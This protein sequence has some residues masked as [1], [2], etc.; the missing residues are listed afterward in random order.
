MHVISTPQWKSIK[1]VVLIFAT[2]LLLSNIV[3]IYVGINSVETVA[4]EHGLSLSNRHIEVEID[5]ILQRLKLIEIKLEL[6]KNIE[7]KL[8]KK[9]PVRQNAFEEID[10][11]NALRNQL[12]KKQ[13]LKLKE[14]Q[15]EKKIKLLS[16]SMNVKSE[17]ELQSNVQRSESNKTQNI[18]VT[19]HR[20]QQNIEVTKL[21]IISDNITN[22]LQNEKVEK[23]NKT[24]VNKFKQVSK[25]Q[26]NYNDIKKENLQRVAKQK[27]EI[28]S[29]RK[30]KKV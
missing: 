5:G 12:F 22:K 16:H 21:Q 19:K 10:Y 25:T 8:I 3:L 15:E 11:R 9:L 4:T 18:E 29:N 1:T 17:Q 6:N 20:G 27:S 23:A 7:N 28:I 13:E 2:F 30:R 14:H 26:V 24:S